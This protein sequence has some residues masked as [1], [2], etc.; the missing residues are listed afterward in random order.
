MLLPLR[1]IETGQEAWRRLS[2]DAIK[3]DAEWVWK[4]LDTSTIHIYMHSAISVYKS[5]IH[6]E[7]G[8]NDKLVQVKTH[9]FK[10]SSSW[11]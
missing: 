9:I 2:L 3:I 7:L 6:K 5:I 8:T 4:F 10:V 1:I 11:E